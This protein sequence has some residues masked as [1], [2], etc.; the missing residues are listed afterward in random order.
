M[1]FYPLRT[2]INSGIRDVMII[3][4]PDHAGHF[5]KLLGSGRKFGVRLTYEIQDEPKGIAH[6]LLIAEDF[7]DNEKVVAILGDNIFEDN[8]KDDVKMF[9]KRGQGAHVFLKDVK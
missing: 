8:I 9:E 1:I 4:G 2:L 7:F 6:A 5:L 3:S